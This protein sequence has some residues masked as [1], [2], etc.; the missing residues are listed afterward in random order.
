VNRF[1]AMLTNNIMVHV[2][3][4]GMEQWLSGTDRGN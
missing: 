1:T 4:V 2:W 3:S